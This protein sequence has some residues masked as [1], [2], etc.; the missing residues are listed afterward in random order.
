[1]IVSE[2]YKFLRTALREEVLIVLAFYQHIVTCFMNTG[3]DCKIIASMRS[4]FA[5]F[6]VDGLYSLLFKQKM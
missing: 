4:I 1:M 2:N 6:T 3:I 5:G